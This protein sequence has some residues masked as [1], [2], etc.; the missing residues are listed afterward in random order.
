VTHK[1]G[2]FCKNWKSYNI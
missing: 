1:I 2:L